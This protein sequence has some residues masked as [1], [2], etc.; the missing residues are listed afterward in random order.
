MTY[1]EIGYM[2]LHRI[3]LKKAK[4]PGLKEVVGALGGR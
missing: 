2:R 4:G 1:K 3:E